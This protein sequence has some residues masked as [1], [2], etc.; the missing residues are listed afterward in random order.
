MDKIIQNA[1]LN[2]ENVKRKNVCARIISG[3]FVGVFKHDLF[4]HEARCLKIY[5]VVICCGCWVRKSKKTR[6]Q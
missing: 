1:T 3:P 2:Y 5:V 6:K 4:Q